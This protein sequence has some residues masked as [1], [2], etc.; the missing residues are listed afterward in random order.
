MKRQYYQGD[1]QKSVKVKK[2]EGRV[3]PY[4]KD[5]EQHLTNLAEERQRRIEMKPGTRH[6]YF[7]EMAEVIRKNLATRRN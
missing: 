1:F 4:P 5:G 3:I 2:R 7:E 6:E